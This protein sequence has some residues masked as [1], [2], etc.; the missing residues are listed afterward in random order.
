[1]PKRL[2]ASTDSTHLG[3]WRLIVTMVTVEEDVAEGD[4]VCDGEEDG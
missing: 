4:G 1:M 2:L 3:D